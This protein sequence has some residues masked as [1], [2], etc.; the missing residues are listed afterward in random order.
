MHDEIHYEIE[1]SHQFSFYQTTLLMQN[2]KILASLLFWEYGEPNTL[3]KN[4]MI[5]QN[6]IGDELKELETK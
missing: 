1:I 2:K 5:R 6:S 4:C 3:C